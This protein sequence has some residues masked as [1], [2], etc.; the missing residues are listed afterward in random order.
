MNPV[1]E[2]STYI[3]ASPQDVYDALA[4]EKGLNSWFTTGSEVEARAGG[5]IVLRWENFG[6]DRLSAQDGGPVLTA[7]P[8]KEFAFKWCPGGPDQPTTV[9][10]KL[11]PYGLGTRVDLTEEG[12]T[13][14]SEAS[15][16]AAMMC[17][18]GWGEAL[19]L[20]KYYLER[21]A[22]YQHPCTWYQAQEAVS[23]PP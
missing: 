5:S 7:E 9:R 23:S 20:L 6:V 1:V 4:T 2:H 11:S 22:D 16:S 19:T 12:Y 10:F 15:L 13:S 14:E 17:A 18:V 3:G 21:P 8:G